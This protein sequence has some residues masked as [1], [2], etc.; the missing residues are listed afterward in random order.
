MATAL[1]GLKELAYKITG[2]T[3]KSNTEN[4]VIT[5]L[6]NDYDNN[7]SS[8]FTF[9]DCVYSNTNGQKLTVTGVTAKQLYEI[10]ANNK[11]GFVVL[12]RTDTPI[13]RYIIISCVHADNDNY[14]FSAVGRRIEKEYGSILFGIVAEGIFSENQEVVFT[15]F[16]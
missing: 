3:P 1:Q 9:L 12:N 13:Q 14:S 6:A 7:Y 8:S 4:G 11:E 15:Q 16:G 2:K 5:E 10:C